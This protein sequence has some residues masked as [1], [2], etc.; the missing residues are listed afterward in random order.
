MSLLLVIGVD[1]IVTEMA[2]NEILVHGLPD[3]RWSSV[4]LKDEEIK[5]AGVGGFK[6]LSNY[7]VLIIEDNI[8]END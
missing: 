2:F 7:T 6:L 3:Q 8:F 5:L 4:V 1:R